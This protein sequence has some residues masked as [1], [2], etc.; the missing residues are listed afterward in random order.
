MQDVLQHQHISKT[1]PSFWLL[2][3]LGWLTYVLVFALDNIFFNAGYN[4]HG[5]DIVLPL[6]LCGLIAGVLTVP[7]RYL[8]RRCWGLNQSALITVILLCSVLVAAI[9]TP[10][11]NVVIWTAAENFDLVKAFTDKAANKGDP[12]FSV[13]TLF[14]TASYS[15][16]MV[17][18]WCCLYFGINYHYMLLREQQ[19]HFNAA[20]LSHIAQIK[21]LRYQINPHFLFNTLNA[22]STLVLNGSKDKANGMLSRLSNFLRFSLDNDPEKKVRL[23]EELK[24]LMLYLDIEKTRFDER[25]EVRFEVEPKAE[26][27]LV[28][29]LLLQPLVENSIKYAIGK[30]AIGGVIEIHAF[31]RRDK[32][33]LQVLDNGPGGEPNHNLL[34]QPKGKRTGVG[35]KN[36]ESRLQVLYPDDY[37]F[38]LEKRIPQGFKVTIVLPMQIG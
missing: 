28:P 16:F 2:H 33:Y 31:C 18:V 26:S 1:K 8:F 11:K 10:L 24:A 20:R 17:L 25:L 23:Y 9:W 13:L 22:I 4:K 21:M 36:I 3:I 27:L 30:M 38:K 19:L 12:H 29:S 15:F 7:L 32:L 34:E 35:L 37:A 14:K 5:L 6:A